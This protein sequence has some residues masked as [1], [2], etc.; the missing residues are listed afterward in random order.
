[1][2]I[3]TFLISLLLVGFGFSSCAQNTPNKAIIGFYNLENLFD[4]INDPH[5][6]DEQFLPQ[7]DFKNHKKISLLPFIFLFNRLSK[8]R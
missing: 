7:G 3:I 6:N 2:K 8:K 1:M 5:K 4:T